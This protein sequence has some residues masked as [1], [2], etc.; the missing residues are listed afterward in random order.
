MATI[1]DNQT[2]IG[3]VPM[4]TIH[5]NQTKIGMV[6][7]ATIHGSQTEIGMVPMATI[8]S[9]Q[10]EIGVVPMATIHQNI[11]TRIRVVPMAMTHIHGI[12]VV[13]GATTDFMKKMMKI[14]TSITEIDDWKDVIGNLMHRTMLLVRIVI[15]Q[16][17]QGIF[18]GM[19]MKL[20]SH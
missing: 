9:S 4:A 6:P 5:H 19:P 3:M 10:T 12:Q 1:H 17:T 7:M 20:N 11:L 2:K 16:D 18:D 8:H 15:Y 13:I 14:Q